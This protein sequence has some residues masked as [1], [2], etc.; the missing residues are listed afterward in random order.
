M[1]F[2]TSMTGENGSNLM[3]T[4]KNGIDF[5]AKPAIPLLLPNTRI[6]QCSLL[7]LNNLH[8]SRNPSTNLF[9]LPVNMT[10]NP[11]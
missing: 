3:R 1:M 2:V 7:H 9:L 11:M 10:P 4:S 5:R 6:N 8:P